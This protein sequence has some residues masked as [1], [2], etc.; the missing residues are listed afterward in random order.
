MVTSNTSD[1]P[2]TRPTGDSDDP[3]FPTGGAGPATEDAPIG[4]R[5]GRN[6]ANVGDEVP[7]A[8]DVTFPDTVPQPAEI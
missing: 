1:L 3:Q 8:T 2:P 6:P 5:V 7:E 4:L